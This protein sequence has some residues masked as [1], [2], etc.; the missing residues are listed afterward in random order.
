MQPGDIPEDVQRFIVDK[1]DTVPHLE[2]LLLLW[3]SRPKG[4]TEEEIAVRVYVPVERA[5][6]ILQDLVRLRL[7]VAHNASTDVYRYD[8]AW[9]ESSQTMP[10]VAETYGRQLVRVAT[11]I[12]SKASS[13]VREFARAFQF[14]N[15]K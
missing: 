7:A 4:W 5:R 10:R 11:L 13:A 2:A 8:P 3:E 15:E 6:A 14:K 12:H 9:D 1:I